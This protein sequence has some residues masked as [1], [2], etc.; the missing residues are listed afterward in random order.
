MPNRILI[1]DDE[2]VQRRLVE[3]TVSRMGYIAETCAGGEEAIARLTKID[4]P[5]VDVM[6]L[7]LVMP[8]LDGMGVLARLREKQ[9]GVPAIV[10]TSQGSIDA[11]ISAMRAGA[12]DFV[13]KPASAERLQVCIKNALQIRDLGS[14]V[15]RIKRKQTGKLTFDDVISA[16]PKMDQVAQ[17][18]ERAAAT[19]I[20]V[21]IE[22]ETGTGKEVIA[23]AIQ[24]SGARSTKPFITVNCGALPENLVES[25]LFGHEKGAFT[26]ATEKHAGKFREAHGGT[27][28]LDEVGELPQDIQV[29]LLRTLQEGEID[30]VGATKPVKIDFRL[31][32]ATNRD[33]IQAVKEGRFRED[34]YYR[35]NVF[36]IRVPALRD[37]REDI[38]LLVEHFSRRFALEEGLRPVRNIAQNAL[39]MLSA[40]DWP[41]NI[42]Q[43][44]NAVFRALVLTDG[45]ELRIEHFP[46]ISAQ[47]GLGLAEQFQAIDPTPSMTTPMDAPITATA[48]NSDRPAEL[49]DQSL[50][51]LV[52][53]GDETGNLRSLSE[54]EQEAISFALDFHH[55][56]VTRVAKALG[57]GRSTLYRKMAEYGLQAAEEQSADA[58]P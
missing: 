49:A 43:L 54:I 14:E 30:P 39:D 38:P 7:D 34:L 51:G 47:L 3:A 26:G 56:H 10:Q 29:K 23:R 44:E 24:G 42:R 22:G 40:F 58:V 11:V 28:F 18:G 8:D 17:I 33:L 20:P 13:V 16:S 21:L 52:R 35:L 12:H 41:G 45:D 50:F 2:P 27:I 32:S 55:G 19:S 25:I 1:V 4:E 36:P 57:I 5:P 37:R 48:Q 31:I 9:I 46:Q 6:L 53:L 15:Q